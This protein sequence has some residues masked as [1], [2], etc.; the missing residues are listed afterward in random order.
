MPL[1]KK[2]ISNWISITVHL[3]REPN[4]H[5]RNHGRRSRRMTI[6][7]MHVHNVYRVTTNK[8]IF[9]GITL[10]LSSRVIAWSPVPVDT[11][12]INPTSKQATW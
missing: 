6:I 11:K 2:A 10:H 3:R 4:A 12:Q 8:D 5:P 9:K 1:R 7:L